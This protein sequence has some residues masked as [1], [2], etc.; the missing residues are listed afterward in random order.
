M[1][2]EQLIEATDVQNIT[3][4]DDL[5]LQRVEDP[6]FTGKLATFERIS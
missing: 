4:V 3:V 6:F 2:D 5:G 1:T